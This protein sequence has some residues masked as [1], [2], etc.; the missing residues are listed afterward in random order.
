MPALKESVDEIA[1]SIDEN[2]ICNVSVLVDALKGIGTYGGR[3]LETDWE[4]PTKRLCD[5]TFRALL[6][7]YYS[8]R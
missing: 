8:Q 6:I 2:G 4:T 5:I 1:S 3:Q 7:L